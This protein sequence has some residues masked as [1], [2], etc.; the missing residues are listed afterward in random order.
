MILDNIAHRDSY[1]QMADL[2]QVLEYMAEQ[3]VQTMPEA[4]VQLREGEVFVNPA[5]FITKPLEECRFELHRN[6][7]DVH[8]IL[9]GSETI[10]VADIAETTETTPYNKVQDI[11]FA[12]CTKGVVCTLYPGDF[13]VCFPQD[14]HRVGI[15]QNAPAPVKKLIG[16]IKV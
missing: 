1:R 9:E 7:A 4:P 13:L 6:F 12:T 16:K 14:A 11:S 8:Y 5:Q 3:T 10:I 15:M 2:T